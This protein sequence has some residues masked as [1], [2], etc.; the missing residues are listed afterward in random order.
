MRAEEVV[1]VVA[2]F[3]RDEEDFALAGAPLREQVAG[4]EEDVRRVGE[5]RSRRAWRWSGRRRGIDVTAEVEGDGG[6]VGLV[7]VEQDC[8]VAARWR[9][10]ASRLLDFV[11]EVL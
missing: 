6:A 4:G 9:R 2:L 1:Y 10:V 3:E 11:G 8:V 7:A 5:G